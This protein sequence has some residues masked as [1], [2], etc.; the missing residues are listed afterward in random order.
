M[1]KCGAI[2]GAINVAVHVDGKDDIWM[3]TVTVMDAAPS[4]CTSTVVAHYPASLAI[5]RDAF[6]SQGSSG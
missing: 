3:S 4:D 5:P 2:C 1:D 6:A